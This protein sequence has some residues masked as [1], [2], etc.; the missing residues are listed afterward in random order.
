MI[1]KYLFF[2]WL[3]TGDFR[4]TQNKDVVCVMTSLQL[5]KKWFEQSC[6]GKY[7]SSSTLNHSETAR[8]AV[9]AHQYLQCAQQYH[10]ST[11]HS[12]DS[13]CAV[14]FRPRR[15]DKLHSYVVLKQNPLHTW[16]LDSK[17]THIHSSIMKRSPF[18]VPRRVL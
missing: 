15:S 13:A 6:G 12:W 11:K 17:T 7:C 16:R 10:T 3:H 4:V 1:E 2:L 8:R 14:T 5:K 9:G 18:Y